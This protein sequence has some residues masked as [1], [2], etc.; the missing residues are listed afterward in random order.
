MGKKLTHYKTGQ[1]IYFREANDIRAVFCNP[2]EN[3]GTDIVWIVLSG[4]AAALPVK[5]T[6]EQVLSVAQINNQ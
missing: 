6:L 4:V 3:N 2:I 1:G 5:E